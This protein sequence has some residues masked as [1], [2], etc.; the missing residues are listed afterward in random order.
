M[1]RSMVEE[2]A[3]TGL[4]TNQRRAAIPINPICL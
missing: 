3:I 4:N 1:A 2:E